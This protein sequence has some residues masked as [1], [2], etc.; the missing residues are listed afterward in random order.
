MCGVAPC[1]IG[2]KIGAMGK[3]IL[4][5]APEFEDVLKVSK[6]SGQSVPTVHAAAVAAWH[7]NKGD[8]E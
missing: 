7:A 1:K 5:A 4:H 2:I 6:E 8:T 3:E